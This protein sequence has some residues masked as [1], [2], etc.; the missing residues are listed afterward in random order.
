MRP[1]LNALLNRLQVGHYL[2]NV[3]MSGRAHALPISSREAAEYPRIS[4]ELS[5]SGGRAA[6]GAGLYLVHV[7]GSG[8]VLDKFGLNKA[9]ASAFISH[10]LGGYRCATDGIKSARVSS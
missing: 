8:R 3:D 4:A 9:E 6:G 2:V 1:G 7:D 5:A 10:V